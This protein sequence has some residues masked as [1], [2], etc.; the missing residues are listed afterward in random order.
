MYAHNGQ[1]IIGALLGIDAV[2]D[3]RNKGN[4]KCDRRALFLRAD[5]D[6][7]EIFDVVAQLIVFLACCALLRAVC[8]NPHT[9]QPDSREWMDTVGMLLL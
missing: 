1:R 5:D 6:R 9:D 3:Q 7:I 4:K 2:A 8:R